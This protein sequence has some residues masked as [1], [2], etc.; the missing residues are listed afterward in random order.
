[1]KL[2]NLH[3]DP[4]SLLYFSEA[5]EVI[6][7]VF[8]DTYVNIPEELRKR[9]VAISKDAEYSYVYARE[10]L[11]KPF[12]LGEEAISKDALYAKLYA[13]NILKGPFPA[14]EE[15]IAEANATW[16]KDMRASRS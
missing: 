13:K 1:M 14:G 11:K 6:P 2:Y 16:R 8:W 7:T 10:V 5:S 15:T 9:E 3:S 4:E 12:A